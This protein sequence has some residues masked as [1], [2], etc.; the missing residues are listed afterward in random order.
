MNLARDWWLPGLTWRSAP[1]LPLAWLLGRAAAARRAAYRLG[2]RVEHHLPVPVLVVGNLTV[3]GSGKTPLVIHLATA[4]AQAGRRPGVISRGFGGRAGAVMEVGPHSQPT[5]TGDEPLL[6]RRR[7]GCPVF[8]GA[9]RVDAARALLAAYPAT[10]LV[11]ADDGLQHLQLARDYQIAVFDER[12]A[13]NGRL[14]PAGPLREPLART[15]MMD[16]LIANGAGAGDAISA[17]TGGNPGRP[18]FA[19][20]LVPGDLY[21]LAN[22]ALTCPPAQFAARHACRVAAVAGIGNPA[23]F[24]ATLRALGLTVVPHPFPDHHPFS[25]DELARIGAQHIVMTEKDAL[26]CEAFD[27]PRIWVAPVTA[28]VDAGLTRSILEKLRGTKAA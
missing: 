28:D 25:R 12:G 13:G 9:R 18:L 23:R 16:A 2:W 6:I 19:M 10:D 8:V 1:L 21:N 24:F 4:L 3:G 27:D 7:T 14:L 22:P 11:I 5:E 17:A 15:A 26:K 20:H